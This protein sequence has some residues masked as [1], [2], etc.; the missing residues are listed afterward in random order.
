[1]TKPTEIAAPVYKVIYE[2]TGRTHFIGNLAAC[3]AWRDRQGLACMYAIRFL[4]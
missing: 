1:M 4:A 3:Q 2:I